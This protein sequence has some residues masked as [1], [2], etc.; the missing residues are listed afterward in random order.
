MQRK[1]FIQTLGIGVF[2]ALFPWKV[3]AVPVQTTS[4]LSEV[5]ASLPDGLPAAEIKALRG[6]IEEAIADPEYFIVVNYRIEWVYDVAHY[7]GLPLDGV[8]IYSA[9]C[10][11]A[12]EVT[13]LREGV[14]HVRD[15]TGALPQ[16]VCL[17]DVSQKEL[18][19]V[20]E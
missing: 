9:D 14:N 19:K 17:P 13:A 5:E 4:H 2:A 3:S 12:T 7:Y 6:H 8:T 18:M 11:P 10:I 16:L 20:R 1:T 15:T